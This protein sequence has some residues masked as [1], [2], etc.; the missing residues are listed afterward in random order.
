M[1]YVLI[2]TTTASC[3]RNAKAYDKAIDAFERAADAY[4]KNHAYPFHYPH[5]YWIPK[6]MLVSFFDSD[7]GYSIQESKII[8][9]CVYNVAFDGHC[10]SFCLEL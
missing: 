9:V 7:S 1:Y 8:N 3:Y 4:Y 5:Q 10:V 2:L 6:S